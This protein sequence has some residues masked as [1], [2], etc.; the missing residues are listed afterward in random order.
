MNGGRR[1]GNDGTARDEAWEQIIGPKFIRFVGDM[2]GGRTPYQWQLQLARAVCITGAWP[3]RL[4]APTGSGKT[5]VIDVHVFANAMAGLKRLTSA[6][7]VDDVALADA[8]AAM[9]VEHVPRRLVLTVNR[10]ALVDDQYEGAAE[11]AARLNGVEAPSSLHDICRGLDVRS[12]IESRCEEDALRCRVTRLRGGEPVDATTR[13]WRYH[14]TECQIICATPDMFGSRLLFHGYGVTPLAAPIEAGLLAYDTVLAADEAHLSRQLVET[15]RSV[16][17]IES[18][19]E[20][21]PLSDAIAPLQVVEMTA[22]PSRYDAQNEQGD[23]TKVIDVR[24]QDLEVDTDLSRRL[25]APKPVTLRIAED[26]ELASA[27]ASACIDAVKAAED[28]QGVVACIVNTPA[29]A[30]DVRRAVDRELKQ[31]KVLGAADPRRQIDMFIGPMRRYDKNEL[32]RSDRYLAMKGDPDACERSGL[33]LVIATQTLEVGIDADFAS[34]ITE[35]APPVALIQRAG[36]INRRGLRASGP[37]TVF[38]HENVA[39][40]IRKSGPYEAEDLEYALRWLA[41]LPQDTGLSAWNACIR[42]PK[43][44]TLQRMALQRLE[45]WDVENLS[46]TDEPLAADLA[47]PRQRPFDITLWL[48]DDLNVDDDPGIGLVVRTLPADDAVAIQVIN[49][50]SPVADES[51][52]IRSWAQI[53]EI[54]KTMMAPDTVR[55]RIFIVRPGMDDEAQQVTVWNGSDPNAAVIGNNGTLSRQVQPGDTLVVDDSAPLFDTNIPMIDLTRRESFAQTTDTARIG[56]QG[57][58]YNR[59]QSDGVVIVT[60]SGKT[61]GRS[62]LRSA[63]LTLQSA[64]AQQSDASDGVIAEGD[65]G[66]ADHALA[67]DVLRQ[68]IAG[69][70]PTLVDAYESGETTIDMVL[71]TDAVDDEPMWLIVRRVSS[72]GESATVRQ[73]LQFGRR[74]GHRVLLETS[75][76]HQCAVR[77]RAEMFSSLLA[78][79]SD[80]CIDLAI[81]ARHHDD[82]KKDTRFQELLH[83]RLQKPR[84]EVYDDTT[85]LAKSTFRFPAYEHA[86]RI[87]LGLRGWRHEQRSAAECWSERTRLQMHDAELVTRLVGTSH[88]HGRSTFAAN[89][90]TLIPQTELQSGDPRIDMPAIHAAAV[91][92]FDR[93]RWETIIDRTNRRY[94]FWGVAYLEAVLRAA[95]CTVSKEGR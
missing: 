77:N 15:A 28:A 72:V 61:D 87:A 76:G 58:I 40:S 94:G 27:M 86:N 8:L 65:D 43:P 22:T 81:A 45:S 83:Y 64:I 9:Q 52:P 56:A 60:E 36:R 16:R 20:E 90:D 69:I 33:R 55:R 67:Y 30:A 49:G 29:M 89:A 82:G 48:R 38:R 21:R 66:Q 70:N 41:E 37:I 24:E 32:L 57:D 91:E 7:D 53:D 47:L 6:G 10:R 34:L 74:A 73:E 79:P 39:K 63:M 4:A 3:Q 62:V 68:A 26:K 1:M 42:P 14:P 46:H 51:F 31:A 19:G 93:G 23:E 17:R 12:G 84:N 80:L 59:C 75:D 13:E 11:L 25:K 50:A 85:Y 2:H 92:L 5:M 95:D 44:A 54:G 71:P 35:L 88:G 78:V 18:L